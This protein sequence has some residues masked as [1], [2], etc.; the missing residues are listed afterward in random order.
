MTAAE[1]TS[2]MPEAPG[3]GAKYSRNITS[4]CSSRMSTKLA[5]EGPGAQRDVPGEQFVGM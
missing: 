1:S 5:V 3:V 4:V 2:P